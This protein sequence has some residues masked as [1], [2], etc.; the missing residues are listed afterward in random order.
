[1][2]AEHIP[3]LADHF[4]GA[5]RV[6]R[7]RNRGRFCFSDNANIDLGLIRHR[8]DH[9]LSG[10]PDG[11]LLVKIVVRVRNRDEEQYRKNDAQHAIAI[12]SCR[13]E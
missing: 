8:E 11:G 9:R 4:F 5:L 12:P 3:Q 7:A 10:Y 2:R 13:D 6:L 1:M